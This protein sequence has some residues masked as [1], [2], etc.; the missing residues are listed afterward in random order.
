MPPRL[1][2][3]ITIGRLALVAAAAAAC[4]TASSYLTP[5]SSTTTLMAGWE[6]HF[7]VEWT[8]E[9]GQGGTRRVVGYLTG[10]QG[11]PAE[12]VRVLAQALDASGA[13]VGQ[14]IGWVPGGVN[15]FQRAYFEVPNLPVAAQYRVTVW[16]YTFLQ[17]PGSGWI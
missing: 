3:L 16:E 5:S 13:V 17:S 1:A 6:R 2:W 12:P 4:T 10:R 9:P 7:A 8:T 14:R 11:E 15:G